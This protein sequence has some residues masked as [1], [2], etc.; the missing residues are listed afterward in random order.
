MLDLSIFPDPVVLAQD[1]RASILPP[2]PDLSVSEWADRERILGPEETSE[3]GRWKTSR[4]PHLKAIM[5]AFSDPEVRTLVIRGSARSGKTEALNNMVGFT[6]HQDPCPVLWVFPTDTL[7]NDHSKEKLEPMLKNTP[8]LAGKISRS[9]SRDSNNTLLRKKFEG[10]YVA[11]VGSNTP[12]SLSS[13]TVRV[14][15]LDEVDKIAK[16][17]KNLGNPIALAKN[18]TI[19]YPGRYKHVL[20]STPSTE[21]E[22]PITDEYERSNTMRLYLP[23]VHC[24]AFDVLEFANLKWPEGKPG[25]AYYQCPHCHER[26][27]DADKAVM[28]TRHQWRAEHPER[29]KEVTGFTLSALVSPWVSFG[30]LAKTFVARRDEGQESLKVFMNEY[31]GVTWKAN[32]GQEAKVE[33]LLKRARESRYSS[34]QVPDQVALLFGAVDVQEDR[35]ELL[36]RGLGVGNRQWTVEHLVLPGNPASMALWDR[37]EEAIRRVW[38]REDGVPMKI[39]RV[40]VDL[41][42]HFTTEAQ[43]FCRRSRML[44]IVSPVRGN[45]RF[46]LKPTK[47]VRDKKGKTYYS[48]D[49]VQIKD[50]VFSRLRIEDPTLPGYQNFPNDLEATYFQQLLSEKRVKGRW[51]KLT[52]STRNEILDL[53]CYVDAAIHI[54]GLTPE[55]LERAYERSLKAVKV[56][57]SSDLVEI[58]REK[59]PLPEPADQDQGEVHDQPEAPPSAPTPPGRPRPARPPRPQRPARPV[60]PVIPRGIIGW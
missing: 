16:E 6:I 44:G 14:V 54:H 47:R 37:L 7:A 41:G 26:L 58:V 5:D 19:T 13:R 31:L 25:D 36:V 55:M 18:R 48:L 60:R 8:A 9:K 2:P 15:I 57:D 23:C 21:G 10:G 39:Q 24:G 17:A 27:T 40:A 59:L 20:S 43:A 45:P 28:L 34:G 12:N 53:T 1:V 3:P 29:G 52:S 56:V 49:T 32:A 11:L 50:T 30:E 51:E 46:Q 4:V 22:S 42:G 33:G 38:V 35:L